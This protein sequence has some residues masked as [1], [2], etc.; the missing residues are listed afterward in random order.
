MIL[1]MG[2][3]LGAATALT[4]VN[5]LLLGGLIAVWARNYRT[6]G[7]R[8]VLGLL[9]FAVA[10]FVENGIA[11]FYLLSMESFYAAGPGVQRAVMVT[12]AAQFAA[13]LILSYVTM[14]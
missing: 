10:M 13:V 1:Q 14:Q 8:F 12:R 3:E 9:A 6:F 7:T 4:G 2:M 5:T 11:L